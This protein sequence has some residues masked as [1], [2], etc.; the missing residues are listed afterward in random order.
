MFFF[1]YFLNIY[2]SLITTLFIFYAISL[3]ALLVLLHTKTLT[4]C[5]LSNT[6]VDLAFSLSSLSFRT[7]LFP[8][9]HVPFL[10]IFCSS[11]M[12]TLVSSLLLQSC[13]FPNSAF[14]T[15]SWH[16]SLILHSV[17]P[18]LP[19]TSLLLHKPPRSVLY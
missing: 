4:L 18:P 11:F 17:S 14:S 16:E 12:S 9:V 19:R 1:K 3:F 13:M 6:A 8:S 15:P 7:S 2:F 10:I 5:T